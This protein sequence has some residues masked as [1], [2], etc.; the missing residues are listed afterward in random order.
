MENN[1]IERTK[2]LDSKNVAGAAAKD[3]AT[4]AAVKRVGDDQN[5]IRKLTVDMMK[6][7]DPKYVPPN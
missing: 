2:D 3:P 6:K 1:V 4:E 5:M 7:L